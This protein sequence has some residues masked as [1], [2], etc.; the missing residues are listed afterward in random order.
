MKEIIIDKKKLYELYI[1]QNLSAR[2][3]SEKYNISID[4]IKWRLKKYRILKDSNLSAQKKKEGAL[5]IR[6]QT[7]L[8][9]YGV[10]HPLQNK[11]IME[12]LNQTNLI[13]YGVK[14]VLGSKKVQQKVRKTMLER[15]NVEYP[16]QSPNIKKQIERTNI[17]RYGANNCLKCKKVQEKR[18][19]T[20]KERYGVE[21]PWQSKEIKEKQEKTMEDRYG[22]VVP[23]RVK[24]LRRK[25]EETNK[26]RYGATSPLKNSNVREKIERTNFKKYETKVSVGSKQVREKIKQTNLKKYGVE[27]SGNLKKF[28]IKAI[29]KSKSNRSKIDGNRFDSSY[30]RDFYDYC[31]TNGIEVEDKQIPIEYEYEKKKHTTFIDFKVNDK[32]IECKGGHLLQGIFDYALGVPIEEK[33]KIYEKYNVI[34]ITDKKGINIIKKCPI[35]LIV[36]DIE[37]FRKNIDK[38]KKI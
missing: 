32:L 33:L 34:L 10:E 17:I 28:R 13:K 27:N 3:I 35:H 15:Y 12:K 8:K 11:I 24:E 1:K 37:N 2:E 26:I 21:S 6:K 7:C 4:S 9:K 18:K 36:E 14:N 19:N 25:I 5:G 22:D 23:M 31:L 16:I 30:E 29:K 38:N 20:M